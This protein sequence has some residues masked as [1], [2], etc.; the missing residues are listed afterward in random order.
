MERSRAA[1]VVVD[2]QNGFVT[3][4]S[5]AVVPSVVDLVRRWPGPTVFTRYHNYPG[6]PYER[7]VGWTAMQGPPE[8]DLVDELA[9]HSRNA[10]VVDKRT[11]SLFTDEG[12]AL[13]AARGWT[14]LAFCGI[15]TDSCVLK[16][17]VD[18]F[19]LGIT[20]WVV[21]DACASDYGPDAHAAGLLC[22]RVMIGAGQLVTAARLLG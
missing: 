9:P 18:A 22:L 10:P 2:V 5:R 12:R 14:E 20:P 16:S 1:L 13:V 3:E 17:A 19:E 15:A 4:S 7:L 8:T 21:T 11:Y 6:S